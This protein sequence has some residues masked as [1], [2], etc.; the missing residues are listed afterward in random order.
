LVIA[1][2][3]SASSINSTMVLICGSFKMSSASVVNS[4][5][6]KDR[7]LSAF[8]ITHFLISRFKSFVLIIS[9]N[10]WPTTPNPNIP[11]VNF[12]L[13]S[14]LFITAGFAVIVVYNYCM[15]AVRYL[16]FRCRPLRHDNRG[17][18]RRGSMLF[19]APRAKPSLLYGQRVDVHFMLLSR[20]RSRDR[21]QC[22]PR[23]RYPLRFSIV[24][25]KHLL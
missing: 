25:E 19:A 17:V 1:K 2:A 20:E 15:A 13:I 22:L 16:R 24:Q 4:S 21:I 7:F 5:A 9:Y 23:A 14:M 11:M 18:R 3:A 8:L 12:S 10:P 6:G